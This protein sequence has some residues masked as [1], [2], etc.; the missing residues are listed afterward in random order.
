MYRADKLSTARGEAH[1]LVL[2]EH[3]ILGVLKKKIKRRNTI[4]AQRHK[5]VGVELQSVMSST[6]NTT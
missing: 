5:V 3:T 1:S 2:F 6:L 4:S